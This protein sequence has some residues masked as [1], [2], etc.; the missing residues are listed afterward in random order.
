MTRP[1]KLQ[2]SLF[3]IQ[4][5]VAVTAIV[6]TM[7]V[8]ASHVRAP[9]ILIPQFALLVLL[10]VVVCMRESNASKIVRAWVR[11]AVC[12]VAGGVVLGAA[13]SL[14]DVMLWLFTWGQHSPV[15]GA[16]MLPVGLLLGLAYPAVVAF[17]V[18]YGE[19]PSLRDDRP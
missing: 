10:V 16:Y 4:V 11:I 5:A 7:A 6:V 12:G 14:V 1:R 13:G 18:R 17:N 2:V 8:Q 15:L 3:A 19:K 9:T